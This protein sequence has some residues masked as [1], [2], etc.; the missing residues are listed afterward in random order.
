MDLKQPTSIKLYQYVNLLVYSIHWPS[1]VKIKPYW[2]VIMDPSSMIYQVVVP[3]STP[4]IPP[5]VERNSRRQ[6][7]SIPQ[8]LCRCRQEKSHCFQLRHLQARGQGVPHQLFGQSLRLMSLLTNCGSCIGK[9]F[10][11]SWS[12]STCIIPY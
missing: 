5:T 4:T 11:V 12:F 1:S 10:V 9:S 8:T 2:L 6:T 3:T 7:P